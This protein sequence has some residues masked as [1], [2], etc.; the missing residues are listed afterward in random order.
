MDPLG[1]ICPIVC[2]SSLVYAGVEPAVWVPTEALSNET[3]PSSQELPTPGDEELQ[4]P[5]EVPGAT[6]HRP[7]FTPAAPVTTALNP[8][9]AAT[10]GPTL[11][12]GPTQATLQQPLVV[13]ASNLPAQPTDA[14][15]TK[16]VTA[17]HLATP[18]AP[19]PSSLP[20][21]QQMLTS[22][23]WPGAM[24]TTKVTVTFAGVPN[25]TNSTPSP[26]VPRFPLVTKAVTVLGPG[27]LP[28]TTTTHQ[29]VPSLELPASPSSRPV[30][31]PAVTSRPPTSSGPHEALPTPAITQ[32]M[33]GTGISQPV[34]AQNFSGPSSPPAEA[35]TAAEQIPVSPL[36][37]KKVETSTERVQPGPSQPMGP[38]AAPLPS[39]VPTALPHPTQHATTAAWPPALPLGSTAATSLSTAAHRLG[40]TPFTSLESTQPP[41]LLS[42]LLPDTSL[43]L[44]KVGTSAPVATPGPKGSAVTPPLQQQAASLPV[45]AT[46][47]ARTLSPALLLTPAVMAQAHRPSHVVSQAT[48]TAPG[49]LLGATLPASGVIA[50]AEGVASPA[51]VAPQKSTTEKMAVLS[52]QV[53]LPPWIYGSAQGG[54]TE[55]TPAVAHTL[56]T[57][58]MEAEGPWASTVTPMPTSYSLSRVS[59]RTA[60]RESSLV[61]LPQLPE[62]HGTS[63]GPQPPAELEG[64]ATTQQSG[65]SAPAQSILEGSAEALAATAEAN[66]SAACMV[67]DLSAFCPVCGPSTPS[68]CCATDL[69][70]HRALTFKA[71]RS[72]FRL[73]DGSL[74]TILTPAPNSWSLENSPGSSEP[75]MPWKIPFGAQEP[76]GCLGVTA[77]V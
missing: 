7:A 36:T 48:G 51:S 15:T 18:G 16:G 53:S 20:L 58:V 37:T 34:Q 17:S 39:P 43:P 6:P 13:T 9:M 77:M 31:S 66:T 40:A 52:K 46:P 33:T 19:E 38:P 30:A 21:S 42:G 63:A 56:A 28:V 24:E 68:C 14:L 11:P 60:S 32:R 27:S 2:I 41:Q 35:R 22:G 25:M 62:A 1:S 47:P 76:V 57:L 55:L 29:P 64:E 23:M 72:V 59:A 61:L 54:P 4:L 73:P 69:G 26:A 3:L 10:E 44:A 50:V 8:P 65:R 75:L 74:V 67:S 49:Q 45:A 5:Q 71:G 70:H 12:P